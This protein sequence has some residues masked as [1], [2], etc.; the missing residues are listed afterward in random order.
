M[1]GQSQRD[2]SIAWFSSPDRK[3]A[4]GDGKCLVSELA[5]GRVGKVEMHALDESSVVAMSR[6]AGGRVMLESVPCPFPTPSITRFEGRPRVARI[7]PNA[8]LLFRRRS[9]APF[10]GAIFYQMGR[11]KEKSL[12]IGS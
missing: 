5:R 2:E 12:G 3:L 6:P 11:F 1:L 10:A 8:V 7:F 4:Q 9:C